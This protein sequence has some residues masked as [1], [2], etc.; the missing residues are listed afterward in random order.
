MEKEFQAKHVCR[1]CV[2]AW[3]QERLVFP[4]RSLV[5]L[6]LSPEILSL[7][8]NSLQWA[9]STSPPDMLTMGSTVH[10]P[11]RTPATLRLKDLSSG[12]QSTVS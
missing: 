12:F 11:A 5:V 2:E 9:G 6:I 10:I 3:R 4:G 7:H 8:E 1:A